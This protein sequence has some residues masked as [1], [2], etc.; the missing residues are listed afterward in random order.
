MPPRLADGAELLG[1][2]EGSGF[3]EAPW[4]ARRGDGQTVQL[5]RLLH[6]V[7]E[8]ADGHRDDAALAEAVSGDFEKRLSPDQ[9]AQL[10]E[11]L[12]GL[13]ILTLPDG[14]DPQ[15]DK[16]DPLLALRYRKALVDPRLVRAV[17]GIFQPL[18]FPPVVLAVLAGVVALDVW[19]FG[20]HGLAQGLRESLYQPALLLLVFGLVVVGAAFHELGH[21]VACRYGGA[22]PGA[23]GAGLYLAW[24]AFYTD[25]TD[26]Y[27]LGRG[28]RLRTDLGGIYFNLV[29][30]L[31][32]AGAYFATGFEP[33]LLVVAIQH[34]E[35][36]HQL[37]PFVR[38]D[39]YY[40]VSDLTG[41]P[42]LFSRLRPILAS[43]V[44]F[45]KTDPRVSELK[46]WPRV[47]ATLWVIAVVPLLLF[48]LAVLAVTFPRI[49]GT[50]WDSAGR[51]VDGMDG[52]VGTAAGV[53]Q[54]LALGLPIL[55]I[56]LLFLRLGRRLAEATWKR[57]DGRPV[58]R[59][60][61]AAAAT[62]SV[63]FLA[64]LW[65]P[66]G[67]YAPIRADERGTLADYVTAIEDVSTGG[68]GVV[69]GRE[70]GT[71]DPAR[72]PEPEP[73]VAPGVPPS[74]GTDPTAE[75]SASS[76][77]TPTASPSDTPTPDGTA[78]PT[79]SP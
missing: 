27:R 12:R 70:R 51:V 43:L 49:V 3:K 79:A 24:P 16:P 40:I 28:G 67:D 42:D 31:A 52:A 46:W 65:L 8:K 14:S 73:S 66:D 71:E 11:K 39:G 77:P 44:P 10:V 75:P 56:G 21:A 48:N 76:S 69:V 17:T 78:S 63:A 13:G 25:V 54:L 6:L 38:L 20:V 26:A 23:M 58:L 64:W 4:L 47:V 59:V 7:A 53:V 55:G 74:P 22:T 1:E 34:L 19:L 32:T 41:V 30:I 33:L 57:T 68:T 62:A 45:R 72:Q 61:G 18:F 36:V 60:G 37:L 29:V 35:I 15:V 5:T 9:A 2:Y 50:A